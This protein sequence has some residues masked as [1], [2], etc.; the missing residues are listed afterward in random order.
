MHTGWR[1]GASN[2][3]EIEDLEKKKNDRQS[4]ILKETERNEVRALR[5]ES[6]TQAW[7]KYIVR[8]DLD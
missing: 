4:K 2:D 8:M 7:D 5:R 6:V 1:K 3:E